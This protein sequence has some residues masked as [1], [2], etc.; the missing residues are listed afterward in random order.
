LRDWRLARSKFLSVARN[1]SA[2]AA[3]RIAAA[4]GLGRIGLRN[5]GNDILVELEPQDG[6]CISSVIPA[7]ISCGQ[8]ERAVEICRGYLVKA[9]V[10]FLNRV[11]IAGDLGKKYRKD[12]ARGLIKEALEREQLDLSDRARAAELLHELGYQSEAST[13]LFDLQKEVL[14]NPDF[15]EV[16]WLLEAMMSCNLST[17]ARLIF[18]RIDMATVREDSLDRYEEMREMLDEPLVADWS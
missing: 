7:L 12:V 1:K 3:V 10:D 2:E 5:A 16:L 18:G 17:S 4:G 6:G 13:I 15:D 8:E 9:D 14:T 11:E